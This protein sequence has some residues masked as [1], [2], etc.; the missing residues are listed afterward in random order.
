M[1]IL[2][3]CNICPPAVA[4]AL[5]QS[6]SVRE[7]WLTGALNRFLAE[8][9]DS[10]QL[11]VCFPAEGERVWLQKKIPLRE[12]RTDHTGGPYREKEVSVY[13]F[14]EDLKRPEVY[15]CG[16]EE[17]FQDGFGP[18]FRN[19]VP[20]CPRDGEKLRQAGTDPGGYPGIGRGMRE[21]LHGGSPGAGTGESHVQGYP[22]KR[23]PAAAAGEV[24]YPGRAG[25]K[26]AAGMRACDR[27]DGV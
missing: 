8:D 15:D 26:G 22:A 2:W 18:Y 3:L 5:G 21:K 9:G 6:Y 12:F 7:G 17:R 13:G 23:Q 10:V 27:T 4:A 24:P 20:P 11:A 14:R 25:T 19:G 1:R 16:M